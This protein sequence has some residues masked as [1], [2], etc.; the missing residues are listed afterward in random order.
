MKNEKLAK[1]EMNLNAL[2]IGTKP[3]TDNYIK[4]C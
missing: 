3:K 1:G 4:T 2:F